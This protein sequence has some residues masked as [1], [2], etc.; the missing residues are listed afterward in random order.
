M[1]FNNNNV[2]PSEF[3]KTYLFVGNYVFAIS[4]FSGADNSY[5]TKLDNCCPGLKCGDCI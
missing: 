2:I 5:I 3:E 4:L 1:G